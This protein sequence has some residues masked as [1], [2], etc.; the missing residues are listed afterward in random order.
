MK[1]TIVLCSLLAAAC[2]STSDAADPIGPP[3][4]AVAEAPTAGAT[5]P[6]L[7]DHKGGLRCGPLDVASGDLAEAC[8]P[9]VGDTVTLTVESPPMRASRWR[10]LAALL[11]AEQFGALPRPMPPGFQAPPV[12]HSVRTSASSTS[13]FV[14]HYVLFWGLLKASTV[15][16]AI[17]GGAIEVVQLWRID[18][19][20]SERD[21]RDGYPDMAD[22]E[23][24]G[25][26]GQ[27]VMPDGLYSIVTFTLR[28]DGDDTR[29]TMVQKGSPAFNEP[30]F[31]M[32]WQGLYFH[33]LK[34]GVELRAAAAHP[35]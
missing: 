13:P 35:E 18:N 21:I 26:V 22:D 11:D 24:A 3:T 14:D 27:V 34:Q 4:G 31:A 30:I 32:H 19:T 12:P 15:S 25:H 5:A 20:W 1:P 6:S 17:D 8:T 28:A 10:V 33:P 23:L 2:G 9:Y 7:L 29:V 16:V